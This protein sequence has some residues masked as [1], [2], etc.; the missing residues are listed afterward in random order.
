VN[1]DPL[2]ILLPSVLTLILCVKFVA[3]GF[4]DLQSKL[5]SFVLLLSFVWIVPGLHRH[6]ERLHRALRAPVASINVFL[7]AH[8]WGLFLYFFVMLIGGGLYVY[9]ISQLP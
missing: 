7:Q 1:L 4:E 2:T 5:I 6:P 9:Y 8:P 3:S